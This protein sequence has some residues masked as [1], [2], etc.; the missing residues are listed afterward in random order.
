[1]MNE[2]VIKMEGYYEKVMLEGNKSY[3]IYQQKK[4]VSPSLILIG[5]SHT[6]YIARIIPGDEKERQEIGAMRVYIVWTW[7]LLL[8]YAETILS[9]V[10]SDCESATPTQVLISLGG[11]QIRFP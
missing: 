8:E 5:D 4:D 1:M 6:K 7:R 11:N 2:E 3:L 9:R 10:K